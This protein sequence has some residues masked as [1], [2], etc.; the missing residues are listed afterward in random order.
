MYFIK[1]EDSFDAAHFLAG[2]H[3]KCS[4]L[5]GHRWRVEIEVSGDL[6]SDDPHLN[7]MI[8][9]FGELKADLKRETERFDHQ[10]IIQ[11]ESLKDTTVQ[12]L[13]EEGFSLVEVMFRPT[14]ENF[15]KYFFD[16]IAEKG[17][18]VKKAWVYETPNNA[19]CYEA[20]S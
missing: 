15:A 11:K 16:K 18:Q 1:V 19:A 3:G 17:Y 6:V 2:Y 12:A 20:E 8:I 4:N 13:Q 14:A 10:F 9:D 5:H 7:G